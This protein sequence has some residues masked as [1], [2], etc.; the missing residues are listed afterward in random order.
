MGLLNTGRWKAVL[1]CI[2][3]VWCAR[4]EQSDIDLVTAGT[5]QGYAWF[6]FLSAAV[7]L[8]TLAV[9]L[10]GWDLGARL[11]DLVTA[12]KEET[13]AET[14]TTAPDEGEEAAQ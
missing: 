12:K 10:I 2:I 4:L 7:W 6:A 8:P 9:S 11:L 14:E 13:E 5:T 3:A 1:L